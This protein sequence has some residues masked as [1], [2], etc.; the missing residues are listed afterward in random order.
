[1]LR[2]QDI[3]FILKYLLTIIVFCNKYC[4]LNV[5]KFLQEW[6]GCKAGN[7]IRLRLSKLGAN[8]KIKIEMKQ[9]KLSKL[10]VVAGFSTPAIN[11]KD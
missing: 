4:K 10:E 6:E 8:Y 1:V 9:P 2:T 3:K 11:T 5:F 7:T